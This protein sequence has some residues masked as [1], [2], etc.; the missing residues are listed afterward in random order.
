M[1]AES[2]TEES[3]DVLGT[4]DSAGF[5]WEDISVPSPP[6][7]HEHLIPPKSSTVSW[8]QYCGDHQ[9]CSVHRGGSLCCNMLW[10][11]VLYPF[12]D[13]WLSASHKGTKWS[14]DLCVIYR[15]YTNW[16]TKIRC[17][18]PL[19]RLMAIIIKE[20]HTQL[21]KAFF[22]KLISVLLMF[23]NSPCWRQ[24]TYEKPTKWCLWFY[25]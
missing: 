14:D 6:K 22:T 13:S 9:T 18:L 19:I 16:I 23:L 17:R 10:E 7:E 25:L 24:L 12:R 21:V 15:S 1:S 5:D 11:S 20:N 2:G 4:R 3:T 8:V